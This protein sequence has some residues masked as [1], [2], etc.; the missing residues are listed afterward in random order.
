MM[1]QVWL[2]T[3]SSRGLGRSIVTAAL[4]AGHQVVATARNPAH[5]TDLVEKYGERV[6]TFALDVTDA[7]AAPRAVAHAVE[8]FGRLDVVVNNAGY[9]DTAAIED[10]TLEDFRAQIDANFYGTVYMT[11]A[12]LPVLREQ[13][14][15]HIIQITSVGGRAHSPG[16]G[17]YQSAKWAVEGFS[18]VLA[19][20]VAPLGI[21]V[22]IVEPG[23][24]R[25][26]WAGSSMTIPP[27]SAPYEQ[28]VG[29]FV[30]RVRRGGK[31]AGDPD[32]AGKVIVEVA[33]LPEPPLRLILGKQALEYATAFDAART[34]SDANWK[35]LSLATEAEDAA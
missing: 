19:L 28:T 31:P 24:F 2:V 16:L 25:T 4:E 33:Q 30:S 8:Q 26:D 11:K 1:S 7:E 3:G 32:K 29:T 20:E 35:H 27:I 18:G 5:L 17:A 23:G 22:T 10:A 14:R 6:S 21:K 12:A 9:G 13:G 34:A 15:G